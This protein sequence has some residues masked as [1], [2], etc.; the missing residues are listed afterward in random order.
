MFIYESVRGYLT[1][2]IVALG[3][4]H[5]GLGVSRGILGIPAI[6]GILGQPDPAERLR[7]AAAATAVRLRPAGAAQ[8][9]YQNAIAQQN[10]INQT[11]I[12]G[13]LSHLQRSIN[14]QQ[15][16]PVYRYTSYPYRYPY[17]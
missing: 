6:S 14:H 9:N 17:R 10:L 11:R 5:L 15:V 16:N 7:P 4:R 8:R 3:L 13:Q 12:E 2:R 1:G